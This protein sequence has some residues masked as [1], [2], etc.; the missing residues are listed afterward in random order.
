MAVLGQLAWAV[1]P[2][3]LFWLYCEGRGQ[4]PTWWLGA[5]GLV[6]GWLLAG[7]ALLV[8]QRWNLDFMAL[9]RRSPLGFPGVFLLG[10][11]L[12]QLLAVGP[13]EEGAKF[14]GALLASAALAQLQ[15]RSPATV[16]SAAT[17]IA[18][19]FTAH[20][21]WLYLASGQA[22][23][24]ERLLGT[25]V[26]ALF[27]AP[28]GYAL[29]M[30]G[31]GPLLAG[32]LQGIGF[33]ALVNWLS[34]TA[35]F[36]ETR[37][38]SYGFFPLLVWL[39]WRFEMLQ[40]RSRDRVPLTLISGRTRAERWWQRGLVAFA[41]ALGGNSLLGVLLLGRA[42]ASAGWGVL[43]G[44]WLLFLSRDVVSA[45]LAWGIW[46]YLRRTARRRHLP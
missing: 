31:G 42:I 15:R 33:H 23:A 44:R 36:P 45:L 38:L 20:E 13:I 24:F 28:Y 12:R 1:I 27:A 16:F 10:T 2:P 6:A 39:F 43:E 41:L 26:H 25:P 29:A 30:G 8:G 19:G 4:S 5:A 11:A 3:A 7:G 35:R 9:A 46:V 22:S 40:R 32:L 18:C 21:T 37:F 14:L 17:A 34:S